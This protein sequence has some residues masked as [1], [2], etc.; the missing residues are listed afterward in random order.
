MRLE[1]VDQGSRV[2]L[3]ALGVLFV[4][5][6]TGF[7][8]FI[9]AGTVWLEILATVIIG[10]LASLAVSAHLVQYFLVRGDE[11][12][13][14]AAEQQTAPAKQDVVQVRRDVART[15]PAPAVQEVVR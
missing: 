12:R 11:K 7:I 15:E 5:A 4:P 13:D 14:E 8:R 10:S 9:G 2:L 1:W 3:T 6:G